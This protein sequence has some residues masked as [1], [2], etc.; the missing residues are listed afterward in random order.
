MLAK[1]I[2]TILIS[3]QILTP[4]MTPKDGEVL[5]VKSQ[6]AG[7]KIETHAPQKI[8]NRSLGMKLTA[9]SAI[10]IDQASGEILYAQNIHEK[11]SIASITKLMAT[12]VFLNTNPDLNSSI[13]IKPE[14]IASAG[15]LNLV[16]GEKITLKNLLYLGLINSDNSAVLA[17]VRSTGMTRQDFVEKMNST[18]KALGLI[19]TSFSDP[20]G[21]DKNNLSTPYE[22]AQLLQ[23]AY[24]H[25]TIQK[26]LPIQSYNF[27]SLSGRSHYIKNTNQ[28]LNSYLN[29]LAGKTGYTEE[30]G[31]CFTSLIKLK[32]NQ[33]IITVVLG[34]PEANDRFQDT[35]AIANWVENN[36]TW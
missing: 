14:D 5:G 8:I 27:I 30:A 12:L 9:D 16:V 25:A 31:N 23:L 7:D 29:I 11:H 3:S 26:I 35:K 1:L 10:A 6:E 22:I 33:E 18:A 15:K 20:V 28:L 2:L 17:L 19:N 21:L 4:S 24:K 36:Y 34:S 13:E 32:N